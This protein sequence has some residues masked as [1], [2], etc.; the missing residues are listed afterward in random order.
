[1]TRVGTARVRPVVAAG[2]ALIIAAGWMAAAH[3]AAPS[4]KE[5]ITACRAQYGKKV[6][7]AIVHKN[8]KVTCQW[9]VVRQMTRAEVFEACRKKHGATTL[10]IRKKKNGWECRYYGRY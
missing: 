7:N 3:A 2:L 5:A 8:G 4:Q 10:L 1:M 9:Q 6:I